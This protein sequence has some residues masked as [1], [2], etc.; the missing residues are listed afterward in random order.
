ME[1]SLSWKNNM[2]STRQLIPG[3]DQNDYFARNNTFN[4]TANHPMYPVLKMDHCQRKLNLSAEN[5]VYACFMV[6][7]LLASIVGNTLV[8]TA[9]CLSRQLR[10]RVTVYFIVSLGML[11][12]INVFIR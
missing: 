10:H 12:I 5:I 4:Q 7:L 11:F 6:F 3:T 1:N 8:I 9:T 2:T